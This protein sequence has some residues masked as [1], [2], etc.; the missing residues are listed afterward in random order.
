[1][2]FSLFFII[3]AKSFSIE[4][5]NAHSDL[6]EPINLCE[7]SQNNNQCIVDNNIEEDAHLLIE[8]ADDNTVLFVY[9]QN[10]NDDR[11]IQIHQLD[12]KG[13][14]FITSNRK[15]HINIDGE[16][17]IAGNVVFDNFFIS[18]S[19]LVLQKKSNIIID[20]VTADN[21]TIGCDENFVCSSIRAQNFY[22]INNNILIQFE[23]K[24]SFEKIHNKS[25]ILTILDG[26]PPKFNF[27]SLNESSRIIVY[28]ETNSLT[29]QSN[30]ER[31]SFSLVAEFLGC[32][33]PQYFNGKDCAECPHNQAPIED[34][35]TTCQPCPDG[36]EYSSDTSRCNSCEP[37]TYLDRNTKKCTLCPI[38]TY[39]PNF[40]ESECLICPENSTTIKTG[41]TSLYSCICPAGYYGRSGEK[42]QQCSET[43]EC[44]FGSLYPLANPGHW[45][46]ENNFYYSNVCQPKYA[47]FGN[48]TCEEGYEGRFC[49]TCSKGYFRLHQSCAK[50]NS[51]V[52][53]IFA[54]IMILLV[55]VMFYF[56]IYQHQFFSMFVIFINFF[57]EFSMF[58]YLN[59]TTKVKS[60]KFFAYLSLTYFNPQIFQPQCYGL[61]SWSAS[62]QVAI[63]IP[64]CIALVLFIC[65]VLSWIV[66][67]LIDFIKNF[68]KNFRNNKSIKKRKFFN[69]NYTFKNCIIV[70]KESIIAS[71]Y[72][73]FPSYFALLMRTIKYSRI[74]MGKTV[75]Y[76]DLEPSSIFN[77]SAI[78][79]SRICSIIILIITAIFVISMDTLI[80]T[81]EIIKEKKN[82]ENQ[83]EKEKS[84]EIKVNIYNKKTLVETIKEH[85][86]ERVFKLDKNYWIFIFHLKYVLICVAWIYLQRFLVFQYGLLLA[87]YTIYF[88]L[89]WS[90]Q[91][92]QYSDD[93]TYAYASE[94]L[95]L[96]FIIAASTQVQESYSSNSVNVILIVLSV[97]FIVLTLVII[98]LLIYDTI[99][100]RKVIK[101]EYQ[102]V[103]TDNDG[104]NQFLNENSS[105]EEINKFLENGATQ[106]MKIMAIPNR[107]NNEKFQHIYKQFVNYAKNSRHDFREFND[108]VS[109]TFRPAM[110]KIINTIIVELPTYIGVFMDNVAYQ[111]KYLA[112]KKDE[113]K[114]HFQGLFTT[115]NF[116]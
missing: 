35:S 51:A 37:G 49:G 18:T 113:D 81:R 9:L 38:G 36:T 41:E 93:N 66:P 7:H 63:A 50:C 97:I 65:S 27:T 2:I 60:T 45:I 76:L 25:T 26:Q 61:H 71:F 12:L 94:L 48:S 57:Q 59:S 34:G 87:L 72:T 14:I 108:Y 100:K 47:C 102:N 106:I 116:E 78:L 67:C 31:R 54:I 43:E 6:L 85:C 42:C 70:F 86:Y 83:E 90:F 23:E 8:S 28:D 3:I 98:G 24:T 112:E 20:T 104:F 82:N 96:I 55:A 69:H 110:L 21:V 4:T 10:I 22:S 68:I 84:D 40:Q 29:R 77:D 53:P 75:D 52:P 80:A 46:D 88:S 17:N 91:P 107:Q 109:S 101:V 92:Y 99:N 89:I 33:I 105:Q 64:I 74:T 95:K 19:K 79:P 16:L 115:I 32:R 58:S 62:I 30:D 114:R 73:F 15:L 44:S 39:Q 111:W 1:M 13:Q 5:N 103:N 56:A 11:V